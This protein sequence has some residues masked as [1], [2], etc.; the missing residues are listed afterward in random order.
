MYLYF[1]FFV[2]VLTAKERL[3]LL[4]Y[5][6][7]S[8]I[9][10]HFSFVIENSTSISSVIEVTEWSVGRPS[11]VTTTTTIITIS[12]ASR[13]RAE[14]YKLNWLMLCMRYERCMCALA[15]CTMY[16]YMYMVEIEIDRVLTE[17][18]SAT[19]RFIMFPCRVRIWSA[20]VDIHADAVVCCLLA[21]NGIEP[22]RSNGTYACS[23]MQ[24]MFISILGIEN[25]YKYVSHSS[26]KC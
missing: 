7:R 12:V 2:Y 19:R 24:F 9:G 22:R 8:V 13:A 23:W 14:I 11:T 6:L 15:L 18:S 5:V 3:W 26:R 20:A 16:L 4:S 1:F 25:G 10:T 21:G 17:R